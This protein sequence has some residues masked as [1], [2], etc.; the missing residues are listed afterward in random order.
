M[1]TNFLLKQVVDKKIHRLFL[2]TN[3]N[4]Y[5]CLVIQ[6]MKYSSLLFLL[7]TT[8]VQVRA[9]DVSPEIQQMTQE[10]IRWT[11]QQFNLYGRVHQHKL[12]S[13]NQLIRSKQAE[14][15]LK[16]KDVQA[17]AD[18]AKGK[19]IN[20]SMQQG[21]MLTVPAG[22]VWKIKR[23]T[24][25]ADIGGYSVLVTSVKFKDSYNEGEKIV[26]PA[27]T[28]EASLLTSDISGISYN[29]VVLENDIH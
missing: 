3:N 2:C 16:K 5:F 21:N 15:E 20:V 14:L 6:L 11:Q 24:C 25:Q 17:S 1:E 7:L 19:V 9:Q 4:C 28:P 29:F 18:T 8:A 13:M 12:D 27:F 10:V 23:V 26:M 22:K